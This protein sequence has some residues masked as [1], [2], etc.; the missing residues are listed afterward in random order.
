MESGPSLRSAVSPASLITLGNLACGVAAMIWA[1]EAQRQGDLSLLEYS[2]WLIVLATIF[3]A[4]DG[5]VARLTQSTSTLGAQL[6]SLADAITF[7][8]APGL[9]LRAL[10]IM[11]QP[12]FET[13][14]HPRLLFVAPILFSVCAVLRL[15]R[16]NTETAEEDPNRE[17]GVFKGLPSP[18][19][20][21]LPTAMLLFYFNVRDPN[22]FLSFDESVIYAINETILRVAPFLLIFMAML[23]VS[24]VPYPHFFSW[25]TRRRNTFRAVAETAIIFGLLLVEP[26]FS[27]FCAAAVFVVVPLVRA[28][29]DMIREARHKPTA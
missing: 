18:A 20:A 28:V 22:F 29:P 14:P 11:E 6:D 16:F 5:K 13:R 19:A 9:M 27:L 26:A 23:M 8:V 24:R 4:L 10:V 25:M 12:V 7:G 21:G 17:H 3:D 15:A 2:G 1:T